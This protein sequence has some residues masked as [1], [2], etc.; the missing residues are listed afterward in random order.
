MRTA[1]R[2]AKY[3]KQ[4]PEWVTWIATDKDGTVTGFETLPLRPRNKP[5]WQSRT[6][7]R[8]FQALYPDLQ[9]RHWVLGT[10]PSIVYNWKT[11]L[12]IKIKPEKA[13]DKFWQVIV[14]GENAT[15][16]MEEMLDE[17]NEF[18]DT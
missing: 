18:L 3:W 10:G 12:E 4:A 14:D 8:E 2:Y 11:S 16:D 6:L 7:S 9:N 17:W 5:F 13:R 15:G 1:T